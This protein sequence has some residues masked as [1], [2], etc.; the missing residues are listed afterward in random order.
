MPKVTIKISLPDDEFNGFSQV[1]GP[2]LLERIKNANVRVNSGGGH[3]QIYISSEDMVGARAS[4]AS[5]TRQAVLFK[6]IKEEVI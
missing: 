1:M 5:V 4:L 2:D 3:L 6:R